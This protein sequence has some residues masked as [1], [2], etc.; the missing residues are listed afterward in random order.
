MMSQ[1]THQVPETFGHILGILHVL[2]VEL[3]I[4]SRVWVNDGDLGVLPGI[5]EGEW[6]DG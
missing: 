5:G 4:F 3:P 2:E 6:Q 1:E